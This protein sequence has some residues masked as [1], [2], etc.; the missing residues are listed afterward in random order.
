MIDSTHLLVTCG[1]SIYAYDFYLFPFVMLKITCRP[2][3]MLGKCSATKQACR[4]NVL[5]HKVNFDEGFFLFFI[6]SLQIS[7]SIF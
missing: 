4:F 7:F 5:R 3:H 1:I 2:F 6:G